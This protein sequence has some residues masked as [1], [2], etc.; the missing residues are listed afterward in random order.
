MA[1]QKVASWYWVVT[2]ALIPVFVVL[3]VILQSVFQQRSQY[4]IEAARIEVEVISNQDKLIPL[5]NQMMGV[6]AVIGFGMADV[7]GYTGDFTDAMTAPGGNAEEEAKPQEERNPVYVVMRR[8]ETEFYEGK[9]QGYMST[10]KWLDN[11]DNKLR[12]YIAYKVQEEYT[13]K[14]KKAADGAWTDNLSTLT[15]SI[16]SSTERTAMVV[17][18]LK[19]DEVNMT[20][21]PDTDIKEGVFRPPVRVTL[22]M[23]FA[24]QFGLIGQLE[25]ASSRYKGLLY[26]EVAGRAGDLYVGFEA[27]VNAKKL[28][29]L[30]KD[31]IITN[32]SQPALLDILK[33]DS[34]EQLD[35]AKSSANAAADEARG[36]SSEFDLR[37]V[38]EKTRL[39]GHE[40]AFEA[41]LSAAKSDA[42]AFEKLINE[43]PLIKSLVKLEKSQADGEIS[44]SDFSRKLCH[45]NLGRGDNIRAGQRF[46]IWRTHG[47]K[48]DKFVA[49]VEIV[50]ALSNS[51]SLCTVLS[52]TDK[53]D[54][55]RKGDSIV[56]RIYHKG[57]FLKIALH[58]DFKAPSEAYGRERLAE[59]LKLAG[60]TIVEKVNPG[61]DLTVT[62]SNLL[63]DER[64]RNARKVLRFETIKE[65]DIRLYIDPR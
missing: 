56:S 43:I 34:V 46:E 20:P 27:G 1:K 8:T 39:T 31:S 29:N 10:R 7:N 45:I 24:K 65:D 26:A 47:R 33:S 37:H 36:N 30:T 4:Q 17:P 60:C 14:A 59:L 18:A 38:S 16:E 9:V 6:S 44:F 23:I 58:G 61:V 5:Q 53:N 32:G 62:G 54:P 11:F 42:E 21:D 51:F 2:V 41:E 63:G 48:R 19:L 49:V 35:L 25:V 55:V 28:A 57:R 15:R 50:R 3:V 40:D 64:Y 13:L 12:R 22:E 52:L